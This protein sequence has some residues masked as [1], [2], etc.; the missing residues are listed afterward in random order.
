MICEVL[1]V[2]V[3]FT[4]YLLIQL[5]LRYYLSL[6]FLSMKVI[7]VQ[8]LLLMSEGKAIPKFVPKPTGM[9]KFS[10]R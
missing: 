4:S 9:S 2:S 10:H 1:A 5:S 8:L 6:D 7:A 3:Q